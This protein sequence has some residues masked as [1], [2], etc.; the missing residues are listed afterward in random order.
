MDGD[1]EI[2]LKVWKEEEDLY[3]SV[4]DNGLG[5]TAEQ[6][7]SLF[8]DSIHVTSKKGSGIGVKNVNE[9]IKL[10]FGEEYGLMIHSEPD[11]GTEITIHL[12]AVPYSR[13]LTE[14]GGL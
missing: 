6:V 7:E 5:M 4:R 3:F 11:E 13:I 12:P 10:Y 8:S 9:R 1:G 2:T 14:G